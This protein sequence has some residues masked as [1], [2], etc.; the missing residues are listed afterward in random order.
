M[1][2]PVIPPCERAPRRRHG[3]AR[4]RSRHRRLGETRLLALATG[5]A[6]SAS[7]LATSPRAKAFD[8]FEIQ[9][10]DGTLDAVGEP[11]LE[12]HVNDVA[13]GQTTSEPPEIPTN[14]VAHATLEPSIGVTRSLE[15]GGYLQTALRPGGPFEFA[16][17]KLRAKLVTPQGWDSH[18]RF[19]ANVEL[20]VIPEAYEADV[21]GGELR[22]IAAW[23]D[24]GW[25][26]A[27]NPI[28]SFGLRG[29]SLRAGP[30]LEPAVAI[31][32][33]VRDLYSFGV[34]Y[35][36]SLGPVASPKPVREQLHYLFMAWNLYVFEKWEVNVGVGGG[37][38]AASD[39]MIL[40]MI[41]G[42]TF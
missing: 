36:G 19:G 27:A 2:E 7:V 5:A 10:Y 14:H 37:L 25:L 8:P 26:A 4:A 23:E 34:E 32:R 33:K 16:G 22:P 30:V 6:L 1:N 24:D 17:A 41:L 28:L 20:S 38:T 31:Y 40:K 21:W 35:Y 9:V 39:G 42:R 3:F 13:K 12:L 18:L 11:G 29:Q 15:L